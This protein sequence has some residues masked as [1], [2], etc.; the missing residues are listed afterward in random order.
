VQDA[1]RVGLGQVA[2][3]T[4]DLRGGLLD[5]LRRLVLTLLAE[6]VGNRADVARLRGD[7]LADLRERWSTCDL[8][9]VFACPAA[10]WACSFACPATS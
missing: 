10:C 4:L 8:I 2:A 1:I 5:V 3:Q 6:R 7:L 9:W